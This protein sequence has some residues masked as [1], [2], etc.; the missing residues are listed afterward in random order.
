M[1]NWRTN[2]IAWVEAQFGH[3]AVGVLSTVYWTLV[4]PLGEERRLHWLVLAMPFVVGLLY[5]W[6]STEARGGRD[7]RTLLGKMLPWR[8]YGSETARL[9]YKVYAIN[10]L[11]LANLGLGKLVL[12]VA[13]L[14]SLSEVTR[15]ALDLLLGPAGDGRVPGIA[16]HLVFTL[17]TLLAYDFGKYVAHY[18]LHRFAWLWEFHK[19]HHAAEVLLMPFTA[20]RVHPVELMVDF[21]FRLI[22][23]AI[24]GGVFA[25]LYPTGGYTEL[26]ILGFNAIAFLIFYPISHLQHS[27]VPLGYGE[28]WSR[29][30]VSPLMHQVHHSCEHRHWDLNFGFVFAIWDRMFGT[31]LVPRTDE[32][33]RLGLPPGNAPVVSLAQVYVQPFI[34]AARALLGRRGGHGSAEP[35]R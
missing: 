4:A 28:R 21:F 27:P 11:L 2:L 16:A 23:T 25:H 12:G 20:L 3:D 18:A 33:I 29:F 19:V 1:D 22:F 9:D 30:L 14:L 15:S 32:P 5:L 24:V 17:L 10:Q 8:A 13:G 26:T 35:D 6:F 31:L 7:V 34:G